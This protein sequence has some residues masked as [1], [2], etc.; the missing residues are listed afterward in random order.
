MVFS[1]NELVQSSR[2]AKDQRAAEGGSEKKKSSRS[3]GLLLNSY[4]E[5]RE[6]GKT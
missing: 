3:S 1:K 5:K 4:Y 2:F 6:I